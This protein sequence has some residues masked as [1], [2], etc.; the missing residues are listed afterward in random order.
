MLP[1]WGK[2]KA[3]VIVT[4][5]YGTPPSVS[6]WD[7]CFAYICLLKAHMAPRGT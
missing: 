4:V 3:E 6:G 5:I 1:S 7:K 2:T